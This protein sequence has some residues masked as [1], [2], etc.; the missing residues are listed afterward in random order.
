MKPFCLFQPGFRPPRNFE[1]PWKPGGGGGETTPGRNPGKPRPFLIGILYPKKRGGGM[2]PI[3]NLYTL[4]ILRQNW[5]QKIG[6]GW[7]TD[8]WNRTFGFP[9]WFSGVQGFLHKPPIV[10]HPRSIPFSCFDCGR[11][12]VWE[13]G[14]SNWRSWEF[15][16][17]SRE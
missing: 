14:H 11:G 8:D 13:W 5:S 7:W 16:L 15:P 12:V 9:C 4:E 3:K 10:G 6:G 17:K 1:A 2:F